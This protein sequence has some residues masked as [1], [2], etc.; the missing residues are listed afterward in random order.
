MNA[1]LAA[2]LRSLAS[3]LLRAS[4]GAPFRGF[5]ASF[6]CGHGDLHAWR[7]VLSTDPPVGRRDDDVVHRVR[8]AAAA[9]VAQRDGEVEMR[10]Y[11]VVFWRWVS[12]WRAI[13]TGATVERSAVRR[14]VTTQYPQ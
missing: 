5:L 11:I 12:R 9:R 7:F 3:A 2:L 10:C 4:L 13:A 6:L 8:S 14:S 1:G